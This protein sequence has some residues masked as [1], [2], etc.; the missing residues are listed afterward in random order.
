MAVMSSLQRCGQFIPQLTSQYGLY[1]R[2][3]G[4]RKSKRRAKIPLI[5]PSDFVAKDSS[6]FKTNVYLVQRSSMIFIIPET[7]EFTFFGL[8]IPEYPEPMLTGVF[9]ELQSKM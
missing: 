1:L 6:E 7:E 4:R 9:K 8:Y 5:I 2:S 3:K